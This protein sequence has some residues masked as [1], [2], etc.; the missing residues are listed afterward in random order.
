[1]DDNTDA[2]SGGGTVTAPVKAAASNVAYVVTR[3]GHGFGVGERI[4]DAPTI[5]KYPHI[6]RFAV[7]VKGA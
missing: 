3:P 2:P 5:A 1:M 6:R 7:P 4:T